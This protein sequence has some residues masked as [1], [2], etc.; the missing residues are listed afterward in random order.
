MTTFKSIV[1]FGAGAIGTYIAAHWSQNSSPVTMFTRPGKENKVQQSQLALTGGSNKVLPPHTLRA[2]S[3]PG[4]L[5]QA[6]LVMV[7]VKY[8]DLQS[9]TEMLAQNLRKEAKIL[10]MLNGIRPLA[11]LRTTFGKDRVVGAMVPFNVIWKG[12][13]ILHRS[14]AGTLTIER[15]PGM[16][17]LAENAESSGVPVHL[18]QTI[19]PVQY[20]K[21]LLNLNNAINALS[22]ETLYGEL[23][24]RDFRIIYAATLEEALAVYERAG[25]EFEKVGPL[26]PNRVIQVL[27]SPNF[28]FNPLVTRIQKIDRE[29]QTSMATDLELGRKT[30][31]E[32]L[33]GEIVSLAN[34]VN[35]DAPI[36]ARLVDL[37][38]AAEKGNPQRFTAQQLRSELG[39]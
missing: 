5:G 11:E 36:N 26:P 15:A 7:S 2:T 23:T 31:I 28:I 37:I 3:D 9:V 19:E 12:E 22:G 32:I 16:L 39:L 33:N 30:E 29:S 14:S 8:G 6:D 1:M 20:G 18:C 34:G 24:R 4:M 21:L 17:N 25:V 38:R 35:C 10:C 13:G 27:R